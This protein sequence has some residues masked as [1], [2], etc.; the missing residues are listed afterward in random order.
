MIKIILTITIFASASISQDTTETATPILLSVPLTT[1]VQPLISVGPIAGGWTQ[2]KDCTSPS[3]SVSVFGFLGKAFDLV[4]GLLKGAAINNWN[5]IV[6]ETQVVAGQ[7]FVGIFQNKSGSQTQY[8]GIKVYVKF[9]QTYQISNFVFGS[10]LASIFAGLG[11][12]QVPSAVIQCPKP[13]WNT[14]FNAQPLSFGIGN[15]VGFSI[16]QNALSGYQNHW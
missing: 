14:H 16:N 13:Q 5:L 7:N 10:S 12:S 3:S 6:S 4:S 1:S 11:V 8:I 15:S 2:H 9:D